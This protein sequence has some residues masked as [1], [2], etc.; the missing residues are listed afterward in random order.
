MKRSRAVLVA[1]GVVV[2]G[3]ALAA[4]A[5]G[6]NDVASAGT[7]ELAGFWLGL[8]H[9]IITPVTFVISLF[10]DNVNIYEVHNNGNWY[11]FGFV[12]GLSIVFG[13][14][15]RAG[16]PRRRPARSAP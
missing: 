15:S 4:C 8:W 2:G 11:D 3:L 6:A 9:G 14:G 7:Q 5:P 1:L 12:F 10:N 13:S 16:A